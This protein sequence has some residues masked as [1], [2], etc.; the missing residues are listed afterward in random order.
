MGPGLLKHDVSPPWKQSDGT[1]SVN[2]ANRRCPND[3]MRIVASAAVRRFSY[4]EQILNIIDP[5]A[6]GC[7]PGRAG[8][9]G[10]SIPCMKVRVDNTL[11]TGHGRCYT[12]A[13]EVF[14]P[15]DDGHCSVIREDIS[16]ELQSVARRGTLNCP[17]DAI[18]IEIE[19]G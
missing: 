11:C 12:L 19:E 15:D 6:N 4:S 8:P 10:V 14:E 1:T 17:E 18:T 13:A 16:A 7:G 5:E 3:E 2:A 9:V